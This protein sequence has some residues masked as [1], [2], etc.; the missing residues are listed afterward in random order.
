MEPSSLFLWRALPLNLFLWH[1]LPSSFTACFAFTFVS[2]CV[3]PSSK[4]LWRVTFKFVSRHVSPSSL[5]HGACRLQVCSMVCVAF[6]FVSWR[7]LPS[8]LFHGVCREIIESDSSSFDFSATSCHNHSV[9]L[10]HK[11]S[12][13]WDRLS[14]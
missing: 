9:E 12:R 10:I 5:F 8:N 7:E 14:S 2:R 11:N 3:S 13:A 6:K 4:F 1:V